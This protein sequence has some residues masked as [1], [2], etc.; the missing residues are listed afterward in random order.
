MVEP[1]NLQ[2]HQREPYKRLISGLNGVLNLN[3]TVFCIEN[4]TFNTLGLCFNLSLVTK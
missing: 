4:W 3:W 1:N 2:F